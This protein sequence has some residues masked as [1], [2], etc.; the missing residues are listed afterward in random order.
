[1]IVDYITLLDSY[2]EAF[3]LEESQQKEFNR[4]KQELM[5][6]LCLILQQINVVLNIMIRKKPTEEQQA[7][8]RQTYTFYKETLSRLFMILFFLNAE[9]QTTQT[10]Q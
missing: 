4:W 8:Y 10:H 3:R 6:N 9:E 2:P 5:Q 7:E 1:M